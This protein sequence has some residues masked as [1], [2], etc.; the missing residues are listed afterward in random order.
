[1]LRSPR[2]TES[3]TDLMMSHEGTMLRNPLSTESSPNTGLTAPIAVRTRRL[4]GTGLPA[5]QVEDM[6]SDAGAM[7]R[8]SRS[9]RSSGRTPGSGDVSADVD[10]EQLYA[11]S[12][13]T[14]VWD[15]WRDESDVFEGLYAYSGDTVVW[16]TCRDESDVSGGDRSS[17]ESATSGSDAFADVDV[18]G[19]YVLSDDHDEWDVAGDGSN[20]SVS[21]VYLGLEQPLSDSGPTLVWDG[22]G[23]LIVVRPPASE[24]GDD[25]AMEPSRF[26]TWIA[27]EARGT[28]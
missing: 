5:S 12:G 4:A 22:A 14:V 28:Q 13:D 27:G 23:Q 16:D 2:R 26:P 1:M 11:Y 10:A 17:A 8:F 19:Q 6:M 20:A 3:T 24:D 21:S 15:T 7:G 9:S 18:D 25:A